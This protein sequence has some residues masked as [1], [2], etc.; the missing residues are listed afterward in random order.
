MVNAMCWWWYLLIL[1]IRTLFCNC[2][3]FMNLH[4]INEIPI[5]FDSVNLRFLGW[6][7]MSVLLIDRDTWWSCL[8]FIIY[9]FNILKSW[10]FCS[11]LHTVII[12]LVFMLM[13]NIFLLYQDNSAHCWIFREKQLEEIPVHTNFQELNVSTDVKNQPLWIP[14]FSLNGCVFLLSNWHMQ[15]LCSFQKYPINVLDL[16]LHRGN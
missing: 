7:F 12:N 13:L 9:V 16:Q 2:W 4:L 8:S 3:K 14:H 5:P 6:K 15:C 10:R 11:L 1:S